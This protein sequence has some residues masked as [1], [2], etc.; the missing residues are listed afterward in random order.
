MQY[1]TQYR[2]IVD[3]ALANEFRPHAAF[4]VHRTRDRAVRFTK[5]VEAPTQCADR[6]AK[7]GRDTVVVTGSGF[8]GIETAT[9][10]PVRQRGIFGKNVAGHYRRA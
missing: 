1:Q 5:T 3:R 4:G 8:T 7:N 6:A 9:E 2:F 10:M